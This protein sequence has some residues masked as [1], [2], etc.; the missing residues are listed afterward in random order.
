MRWTVSA[1]VAV[2]LLLGAGGVAVAHFRSGSAAVASVTFKPTTCSDAYRLVSLRPSQITAANSVCLV[3]TLKFTGELAGSVAQAYTVSADKAGPT[4][5]CVTPKRWDAYPQAILAMVIGSKAYRLRIAP[6]GT[7][8]H[9]GLTIHNLANVVDLAAINNPSTDW[10]QATGTV[11]LNPDG[12]TGT[13]DAS[14]LRDVAGAQPVHVTGQWACGAPALPTFDASVPCAS[15]YGLNHL[16]D[17]DVARMKAQA[18]NS[19]DLTFSGDIS[20]HLDHAITD[21]AISAPPGI[22]GDNHCGTAGNNYDAS[23]KFSIGDES[24]L[25]NL[26]PRSPSDSPIGPGQYAAGTGL[27]SANAY[28]W[29]GN[30]DPGHNGLFVT[31][32]NVYWYGSS[33]SFTI[34]TDMKSGTIDES[35]NGTIDHAGNTVHISGSWRCAA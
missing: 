10:S 21:T 17:T 26:Y 3:Q 16:Q 12:V 6:L 14:L 4:S 1:V 9:Q 27:F 28:L 33:G 15:F 23:L 30:A 32:Q 5:E 35:F 18:C 29:L 7:S 19:Q 24:F 2:V 8:E 11:T 31:D 22:D 25:L 20:A 13:L 34:A